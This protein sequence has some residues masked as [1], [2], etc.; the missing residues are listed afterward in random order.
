MIAPLRANTLEGQRVFEVQGLASQSL[1]LVLSCP[2]SGSYYPRSM[3]R[4][5]QLDEQELRASED[6]AVDTL[7]APLI[8]RG[9]VRLK[10]KI[11]RAFVDLNRQPDELDESMFEALAEHTTAQNTPRVR[12][13]LGVV[14]AVVSQDKPLYSQPLPAGEAERRLAAVYHPYHMALD[15]L[16]QRTLA[17]FGCCL[18]VDC[19]SMPDQP[20]LAD[21]VI[22]TRFSA[23]CD[24]G[25]A[26]TLQAALSRSAHQ[27]T[28]NAPF[29][30]GAITQR[31]AKSN[32]NFEG[33][34]I[35]SQSVQIEVNRRLYLDGFELSAKAQTIQ[36]LVCEAVLAALA[37]LPQNMN[38]DAQRLAA[39]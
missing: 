25:I 16:V 19:H 3:R 4:L 7:F 38:Q 15:E 8:E 37:H 2:H 32:R 5:T 22:G 10:A 11:A 35:A 9:A 33:A 21:F 26:A 36:E 23:S 29:A 34:S 27:V 14:P 12:A 30:G 18:L 28:L 17:R 39:Q 1:P 13:N 6:V 20:Q 31:Y 24:E